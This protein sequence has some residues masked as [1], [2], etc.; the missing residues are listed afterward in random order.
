MSDMVEK[1]LNGLIDSMHKHMAKGN[2]EK[3]VSVATEIKKAVAVEEPKAEVKRE[4]S[5]FDKFLQQAKDAKPKPKANELNFS[6]KKQT[7][8]IKKKK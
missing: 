7:K 3:K 5:A 8:D 2:G 1:V 6:S 4:P